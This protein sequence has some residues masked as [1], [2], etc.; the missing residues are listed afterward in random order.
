MANAQK[1]RLGLKPR[2]IM[3]AD[4]DRMVEACVHDALLPC[5]KFEVAYK[6]ASLGKVSPTL[7]FL[8]RLVK[9]VPGIDEDD[10]AAF[11][12]FTSDEMSYV[13]REAT[14]PGYLEIKDARLWLSLAGER[15]FGDDGEPQIYKVERRQRAFGFDLLSMAPE[16]PLRLSPTQLA[17]PELPLED[18]KT[19]GN[20][21][22]HLPAQF[23]RFFR[24]LADRSDRDQ[25]ERRDLYSIDAVS[26]QDRF[27]TPVRIRTFVQASTPHLVETVD[28]N[29][30]R[31]EH[32]L[33]DRA[34][35][36]HAAAAFIDNIKTS[37]NQLNSQGAYDLLLDI[38]PEFL[39]EFK[40]RDGLAIERYWRSALSRAGEPRRDRRTI[41]IAGSIL[42]GANIERVS[43]VL[44]YGYG[45]QSKD[46]APGFIVTVAPQIY[47]WGASSLYADMLTLIRTK[48]GSTF[49]GAADI[50]SV[51]LSSGKVERYVARTFDVAAGSERAVFPA[52]LELWLVPGAMVIAM[53]HAP[54][55]V[56]VGFPV[57][58]GLASFDKA[59][60]ERAQ[61]L[62]R[63]R[64][65]D[66]AVDSE[67]AT[68]LSLRLAADAKPE[69][70]PLPE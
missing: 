23:R 68:L 7:E 6:V 32:E 15:L 42:T 8:L 5:R 41:A 10:A 12:G 53:V 70:D 36:E 26:P 63:D 39:K 1:P 40:I 67:L 9:A 33:S 64:L 20:V 49:E 3:P 30:W 19:T 38:A 28:L 56:S 44:G 61:A 45:P 31:P 35:V 59:V 17:L 21:A 18:P 37:A 4:E 24:D 48:A 22:E 54:I 46:L 50:K 57:P 34:A 69:A 29:S 60:I 52:S 27:Q 47:H 65:P 14:G 11:F 51:C 25:I 55:G 13:L 16:P 2:E 58:L 62:V 66:F 43:S